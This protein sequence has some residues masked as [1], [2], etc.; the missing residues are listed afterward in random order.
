MSRTDDVAGELR[1]IAHAIK[2]LGS[3]RPYLTSSEC[4]WLAE[5]GRDACDALD[6]GIGAIVT[7]PS[8]AAR[9]EPAPQ[10]EQ[11]PEPESAPPCEIRCSIK[12]PH[13]RRPA[14]PAKP[15]ARFP[16]GVMAPTG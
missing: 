4:V 3:L 6:H 7:L 12:Q 5:L 10:P 14:Q 11:S 16:A 13:R 2:R 8:L 9:R 1:Y 15:R